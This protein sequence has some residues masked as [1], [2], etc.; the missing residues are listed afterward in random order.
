M[1]NRSTIHTHTHTLHI[2]W[3]FFGG[4]RDAMGHTYSY[5]KLHVDHLGYPGMED[6][7]LSKMEKGSTC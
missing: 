3:G 4:V 6:A 7:E 2:F 5:I 1:S